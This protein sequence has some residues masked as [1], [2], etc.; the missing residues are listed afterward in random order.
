MHFP[1][2]AVSLSL[3][4]SALPRSS[5]LSRT[6]HEMSSIPLIDDMLYVSLLCVVGTTTVPD[7]KR[8]TRNWSAFL[9]KKSVFGCL[10]TGTTR[11]WR[12]SVGKGD[13]AVHTFFA[14]LVFPAQHVLSS[15]PFPV[16]CL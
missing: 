14:Y 11:Q 9:A 4:Y 13:G 10:G 16:A 12:R 1:N 3:Y 2:F 15:F 7:T 6:P 8:G 5:V